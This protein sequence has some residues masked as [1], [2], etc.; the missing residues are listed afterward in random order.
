MGTDLLHST[1]YHPQTGGQTERVNQIL[2][3]ML[4]ACAISY[5]EKWNDCWPLAEFC[6]NNSYQESIRMAPFEALYGKKCRTPPNWVE[7][8]DRGHFGP[9]F[10][11]EAREQ[12]CTIQGHMKAAQHRQK[13]YADKRRRPLQFEVDDYVYLKVSPMR[14]V[15]RFGVRGKLAPRYVGPYKILER[16][17]H[18]AYRIQL[19]DIL[20]AVHNVFHVSQLKKCLRV[21][22]NEVVEI[23]GLPLQPDLSYIEHPIKILDEKERVT[24][25]KVVKFY[26]VQWQNHSE[27]E[28]TWELESY[29]LEH[30][31]HLIPGSSR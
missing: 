20:S 19:P 13:T 5:P 14:G 26:K 10:I 4:R 11:K 1:A 30:Y 27:D 24:R 28:A 7:V 3:D 17:G 29:F 31:P 18:V 8:G 21:P 12:V 22:D 23:E 25:N 16:C 2:E 15:H 9:D 6:Y